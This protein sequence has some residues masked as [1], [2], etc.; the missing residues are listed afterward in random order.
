VN[1]LKEAIEE[2]KDID[3]DEAKELLQFVADKL[4]VKPE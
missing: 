1:K 3:P 2:V 4:N